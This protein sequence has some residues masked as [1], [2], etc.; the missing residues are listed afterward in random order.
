MGV[1]DILYMWEAV[2]DVLY[3]CEGVYDMCVSTYPCESKQ[4]GVW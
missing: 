2:Y 1:Y 3:I 4:Y